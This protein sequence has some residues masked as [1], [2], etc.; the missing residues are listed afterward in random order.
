MKIQIILSESRKFAKRGQIMAELGQTA[1]MK[2]VD[3]D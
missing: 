3:K 1:Y 2:Q